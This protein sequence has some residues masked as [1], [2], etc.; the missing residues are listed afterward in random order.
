[1]SLFQSGFFST[2]KVAVG[3]SLYGGII[4]YIDSNYFYIVKESQL[5]NAG[6]LFPCNGNWPGTSADIGTSAYN[7]NII[8]SICPSSTVVIDCQAYSVTMDGILYDDWEVPS[9]GDL[10]AIYD[11]LVATGKSSFAWGTGLRTSSTQLTSLT[12]QYFNSS[13]VEI[14]SL[15]L[16]GGWRM[17][18]VR[19]QLR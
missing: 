6:N 15:N 14:Q 4:Y 12:I 3:Q 9:S 17:L 13:G 1:M 8:K 16:S 2:S 7:T 10:R 18:P 19:K 5:P 11:N